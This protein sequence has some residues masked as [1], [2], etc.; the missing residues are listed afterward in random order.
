MGLV[1]R[2]GYLLTR[3]E[4]TSSLKHLYSPVPSDGFH[5]LIKKEN[6]REPEN[7]KK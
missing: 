4:L 3:V 5:F 7:K 2:S 1:P 6:P